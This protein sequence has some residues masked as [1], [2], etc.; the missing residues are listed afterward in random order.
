MKYLNTLFFSFVLTFISFS[1]IEKPLAICP[2]LLMS[3]NSV[4]CYGNSN[5]AAY[6][7]AINGS[8]SYIYSW[9]NGVNTP[10][11]IGLPVGTYTVNVL[12]LVS[13]CTVVGAYVVGS[14]DP[15]TTGESI[16]NVLCHGQN[17]GSVNVTT[18]GG[19]T[20]YQFNWSN[21]TSNEDLT[22]AGAGIYTLNIQD[23]RGCTYSEV[24]NITQPLE[25]L[26]GAGLVEDASCFASATG[27]INLTVWGGTTSYSY[28]WNTGAIS[29]DISNLA[30]G[31]YSVLITD[32]NGCT[33]NS[34]FFVGQP[35]PISGSM[36]S[37]DVLCYGESTGTA[38]ALIAGGTV[39]YDYSWQNSLNLFSVNNST[40]SGIPA[41]AYQV[42]VTDDNGCV[43][44]DNVNV[45]QPADLQ[46]TTAITNVSCY[47]GSDGAVNVS[48][49]GGT[50]TYTYN[51][52]NSQGAFITSSQD[53]VNVPADIYQLVVTD[54]NGCTEVLNP[55]VTQP[56]SPISGTYT[57]ADVL[58]FGQNTG[59]IDLTASGG[60]APYFYAWSSGQST[61][62]ISNLLSG[63]Y[64]FTIIDNNGCTESG[65]VTVQQPLAPLTVNHL[66]EDVN[67][68]GE[69]NGSIF[70]DVNGGTAGYTFLW[71]NSTFILSYT[72]EDLINF[73]AD[74]YRFEVTDANGCKVI[75]TLTIGEP[76]ELIAT[77]QTTHVLCYGESTG[78]LDLTVIGG[79]T[80]YQYYWSN[81]PVSE[82]QTGL[83]AGNYSVTVIDDHGCEDF[84]STTILQPQDTI[85]FTYEVFDVR[86]NGGADGEI[87]LFVEGGTSPYNYL[88][89]NGESTS[90]I[91][92]LIAG[93]YQF[94]ITDANACVFIDFITVDQPD[95]IALNPI[96][97]PVTCYG[98]VDGVININSTGGTEPFN[99]SWYNSVY[100]LA[101]QTEDLN[102]FAADIYQVEVVDSNGCFYEEFIELPQ[103]DSLYVEYEIKQ[104]T[105]YGWSDGAVYIDIYGG[106]PGYTT[107]WSNGSFNEDLE[108]VMS[109]TFDLVVL[110]TKGCT[111]SLTFFVPQPDTMTVTF[112]HEPV[113]CIDQSDGVAFAFAE[114]GN[115]GYS[116]LWENGSIADSSQN[117]SH[118]W[119]TVTV[120][121][122]LG[123]IAIDSVFI[124]RLDGPCIV[125]P[126]AFT[127]NGDVYNDAWQID[128]IHLY[129]NLE[130]LVFNKWGNRIH[131]QKGGYE[132]WDGTI[133]GS[134]AP[135]DTYYYIININYLDRQP[136]RGNVTILR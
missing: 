2:T 122:V 10:N 96:V 14:P 99:Y 90:N 54:F 15:I 79:T 4:S 104:V 131:F 71:Q 82:D 118:D 60:T 50:P 36:S 108:N 112:E 43:Y 5:G 127:P 44:V 55:T 16:T 101:T 49:F 97:T 111:D 68:F 93:T 113:S 53:L 22:N 12:D 37:T 63:T 41:G 59:S 39:P 8:G 23:F 48:V 70:L 125:P 129:P 31:N 84:E 110:D 46:L 98:F 20:P 30:T 33:L 128:N 32:Y 3:G 124:T 13:G 109:D 120:T 130:V 45:F 81:G 61:Q 107:Q 121:D 47:G 86:C 65:S 6:V 24:Y 29:Q 136:V 117:L 91:D 88:W 73:V 64:I 119:Q 57:V 115:G 105:C 69:S 28:L 75:D 114:G 62:D 102:G 26:S 40:I 72:N 52:T 9:S 83:I 27:E 133:N 135:S 42:T 95:P 85:S 116:Y 100:A 7:N 78:E 87:E 58:C 123:C 35:A 67:C 77:I 106:N 66:I 103:P 89:S 126:N 1:E 56:L 38:T 92:D 74:D 18:Y 94:T 76:D 51:W 17:T 25:P 134:P 132:S 80:P 19:T 34:A 11:N 21:G